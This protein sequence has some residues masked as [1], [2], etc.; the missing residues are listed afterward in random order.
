MTDLGTLGG[1]NSWAYGINASGQVVGSSTLTDTTNWTP[2]G[3]FWPGHGKMQDL[4]TL[5]GTSSF[6]FSINNTGQVVGSSTLAGDKIGHAFLWQSGHKIKDLGALPG[7]SNSQA[8]GVVDGGQA[9]GQSCNAAGSVCHAVMWGKG[10]I[11]DL[12]TLIPPNSGWVLNWAQTANAKGLI[13]GGGTYK[14][15]PA[16]GYLLTPVN[17]S[18][19]ATGRQSPAWTLSLRVSSWIQEG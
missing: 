19:L 1:P 17:V 18:E 9:F 8:N 12:N 7:D 15:G 10:K 16:S 13:I 11:T 5:G 3:F 6:A 14:G 4:G 2:H